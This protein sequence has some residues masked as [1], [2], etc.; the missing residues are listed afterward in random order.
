M[1]RHPAAQENSAKAEG[2]LR[3]FFTK[4]AAKNAP[5]YVKVARCTLLFAVGFPAVQLGLMHLPGRPVTPQEEVQL[6]EIFKDS[7]KYGEVRVHSSALMDRW[8]NPLGGAM[9][10]TV[11]MAHTH[12]SVIAMSRSVAADD[13]AKPG[14]TEDTR[15]VFTHENVHVWQF[16]NCPAR[17]TMLTV[18]NAF[19][20]F[21]DPEHVY[22]YKLKPGGD[23][24][25]YSYE[26]QATLITDYYTRLKLGKM[27]IHAQN[28]ES[29]AQLEKLYRETLA[30]FSANPHYLSRN[31][32]SLK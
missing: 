21:R 9:T 10:D 3:D 22:E 14:V 30:K 1:D 29:S 19:N 4:A 24:L 26:Q 12:G 32:P 11:S 5:W 6:A 27:P 17:M 31:C 20:S 8:V 15:E 18:A 7:I 16:Q 2:R 25:D 23:L 28:Q 13:Y